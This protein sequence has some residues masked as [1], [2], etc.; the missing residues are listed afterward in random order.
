MN[1]QASTP[2]LPDAFSPHVTVATVVERDGRFLFVEEHSE[3]AVVIN[4]PAGHLEAGESLVEAAV[5][6]TL[7]ETRWHV[8]IDAILGLG[9]YCSPNNGTTYQRTTFVATA[10]H[11]DLEAVL[12]TGIIRSL[13]LSF[14]ELQQRSEQLRSPMVIDCVQRYLDGHR[15]PLSL[16]N[17][18]KP[19]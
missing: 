1:S 8:S 10:L 4:Q 14:E 18:C 15:Y 13:W 6:E 19:G 16:L 7:E 11:E 3:G 12:D 5:R 2:Q 9:L 17:D